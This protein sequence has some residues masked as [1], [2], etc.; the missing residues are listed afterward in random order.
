MSRRHYGIPMHEPRPPSAAATR[1]AGWRGETLVGAI[2]AILIVLG[3]AVY[4]V[5]KTLTH[6]GNTSSDRTTDYAKQGH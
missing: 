3:F 5:S 2:I 4:E 1:A 6:A